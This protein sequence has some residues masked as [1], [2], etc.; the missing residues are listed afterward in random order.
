M[1]KGPEAYS[2]DFAL[3]F[4]GNERPLAEEIRDTRRFNVNCGRN[5]CYEDREW[6][7]FLN[8]KSNSA[9]RE[10]QTGKGGASLLLNQCDSSEGGWIAFH[11][12]KIVQLLPRCDTPC[13]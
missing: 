9:G 8:Y 12:R 3:S 5:R 2:F 11:L 4:A 6:G 10:T 7:T 1:S 13:E